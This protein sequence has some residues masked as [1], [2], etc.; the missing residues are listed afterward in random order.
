MVKLSAFCFLLSAFRQRFLSAFC[1]LPRAVPPASRPAAREV[2]PR[3]TR[4]SGRGRIRIRRRRTRYAAYYAGC[5][6]DARRPAV[7]QPS[8]RAVHPDQAA[9]K[10]LADETAVGI[11]TMLHLF[12]CLLM[13]GH[14][15]SQAAR[16][17]QAVSLYPD[18][19]CGNDE[20]KGGTVVVPTWRGG[21]SDGS[22]TCDAAHLLIS[23]SPSTQCPPP[24]LIHY[25][26]VLDHIC[27]SDL[28]VHRVRPHSGHMPE[29]VPQQQMLCL[30]LHYAWC[31]VPPISLSTARWHH[32]VLKQ[33][34][35]L[36]RC[37]NETTTAR[38]NEQVDSISLGQP[39]G[40]TRLYAR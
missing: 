15:R 12:A 5:A 17:A 33:P 35:L 34:R 25:M 11:P 28:Q 10:H 40:H 36:Q 19:Y 22:R 2:G 31:S 27:V 20:G 4:R 39:I 37:P 18:P 23:H 14:A 21:L 26:R 16:E 29:H 24:E 38:C 13:A 9:I 3:R 30:R 32:N 8:Y 1:F 6:T 7:A